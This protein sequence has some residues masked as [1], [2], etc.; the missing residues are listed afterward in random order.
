MDLPAP[1]RQEHLYQFPPPPPLSV[2]LFSLLNTRASLFR[3]PRRLCLSSASTSSVV[4]FRVIMRAAA[5]LGFYLGRGKKL[6]SRD[7]MAF[8][9]PYLLRVSSSYVPGDGTGFVHTTF[10]LFTPFFRRC[11]WSAISAERY[12]R[13]STSNRILNLR[14]LNLYSF[15]IVQSTILSQTFS[16]LVSC[17][18]WSQIWILRLQKIESSGYLS[19]LKSLCTGSY[20][21]TKL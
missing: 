17:W 15:S 18:L 10:P 11:S 12:I 8:P 5:S 20:L 2:P 13:C 7:A 1:R 4:R 6:I 19:S 9:Y 16:F 3:Y 14:I 21:V